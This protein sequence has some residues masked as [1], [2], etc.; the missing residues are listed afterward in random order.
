MGRAV[1]DESHR[2]SVE[3]QSTSIPASLCGTS[4]FGAPAALAQQ[5]A[6][7][8]ELSAKFALLQRFGIIENETHTS[9]AFAK[10]CSR[11]ALHEVPDALFEHGQMER[12]C[13][14]L[15]PLPACWLAVHGTHDPRQ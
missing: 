2:L 7:Q 14:S 4:G 12:R 13:D 15:L 9:R 6:E 3:Q 8:L 10:E 5:I 11:L 1:A